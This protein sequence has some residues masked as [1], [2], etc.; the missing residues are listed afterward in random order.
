[1]TKW[2]FKLTVDLG[3]AVQKKQDQKST[4]WMC[5]NDSAADLQMRCEM[6]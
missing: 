2:L 1:M 4:A 6:P 3:V 5:K